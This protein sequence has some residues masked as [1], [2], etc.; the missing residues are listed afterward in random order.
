M[1]VSYLAGIFDKYHHLFTCQLIFQIIR[2]L[3]NVLW[4]GRWF[5]RRRRTSLQTQKTVCR[6]HAATSMV[7]NQLHQLHLLG[8]DGIGFCI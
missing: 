5:A 8:V 4:I 6:S 7:Y 3:L 1:D 2:H